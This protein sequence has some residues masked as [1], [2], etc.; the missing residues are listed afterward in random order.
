MS[1]WHVLTV[2]K[3]VRTSDIR[4]CCVSKEENGKPLEGFPYHLP[5]R[6]KKLQ[7]TNHK[8]QAKCQEHVRDRL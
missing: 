3:H 1:H 2:L 5:K 7:K 8:T 6:D 4:K